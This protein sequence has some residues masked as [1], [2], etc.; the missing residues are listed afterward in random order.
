MSKMRPTPKV[1]IPK[2][3]KEEFDSEVK[4]IQILEETQGII[5]RRLLAKLELEDNSQ[6]ADIIFDYAF[7]RTPYVTDWIKFQ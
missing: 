1:V 7:N 6:E 5:Y 2:S 4:Q 3:L